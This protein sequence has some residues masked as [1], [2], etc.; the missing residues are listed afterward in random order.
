[1]MTFNEML[2]AIED[3]DSA[4][5]L[6]DAIKLLAESKNLESIPHLIRSLGYNNP[7]AAVDRKSTRLNSSHV[8]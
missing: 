3:A 8:D 6:A 5:K 4:V 2:Q 1:M 7:G